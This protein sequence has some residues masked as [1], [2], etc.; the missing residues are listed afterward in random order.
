M[1]VYSIDSD[2]TMS[3]VSTQ[4]T[5]CSRSVA[6]WHVVW[7][8]V[9]RQWWSGCVQICL[10]LSCGREVLEPKEISERLVTSTAFERLATLKIDELVSEN[11]AATSSR[12]FGN[13]EIHEL[14]SVWI[15]ASS[16]ILERTFRSKTAFIHVDESSE[17]FVASSRRTSKVHQALR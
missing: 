16:K 2:Q 8:Q 9:K 6:N 17:R 14:V 12:T 13:L 7:L 10:S 15:T 5:D 3:V 11:L 4:T 1:S